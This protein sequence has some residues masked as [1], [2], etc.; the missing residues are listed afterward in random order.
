[1]HSYQECTVLI[2]EDEAPLR[3]AVVKELNNTGFKVLEAPDGTT[4]INFLK[5]N[6][7]KIDV[8]LLD[9]TIPG[10]SSAEV[11]AEA[12]KIRPDIRV[13]LTSAYSEEMVTAPLPGSRIWRFIRK[14]FQLAD[15]VK[16]LRRA[17]S[18]SFI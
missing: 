6:V 10:A 3:Q 14:P 7:E 16:T 12:A 5:A 8:I 18:A 2:V 1:V 4:A 13:I 15:L 11:I 17:S 9:M